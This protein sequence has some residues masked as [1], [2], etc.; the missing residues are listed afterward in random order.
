VRRI[1]VVA[2]DA[3]VPATQWLELHPGAS[4]RRYGTL[5]PVAFGE[6]DACWLLDAPD[7]AHD[8]LPPEGEAWLARGGRLLVTG[9]ASPR[10]FPGLAGFGAHPLFAQT[11][12]LVGAPDPRSFGEAGPVPDD[13]SVVAVALHDPAGARPRAVRGEVVAWERRVGEGGVLRL[14]LSPPSAVAS[15]AAVAMLRNALL[16]DAIP[17]AERGAAVCWPAP[18]AAAPREPARPLPRLPDLGAWGAASA[19][20]PADSQG[21]RVRTLAGPGDARPAE[22]WCSGVRVLHDPA[23]YLDGVRVSSGGDGTLTERWLSALE[24]PVA[25]WEVEASATDTTV[26][27]DW[28]TDLLPAAPLPPGALGD[29]S[30]NLTEGGHRVWLGARAAGMQVALALEGGRVAVVES[31]AGPGLRFTAEG[32]GRLRLALIAATGDAD[33]D[34]TLEL[35]RRKPLVQLRS[36]RAQHAR[37]LSDY[38]SAFDAAPDVS[39]GPRIE[40]AKRALDARLVE[41]PGLGRG[42]AA[43]GGP[44]ML[45]GVRDAAVAAAALLGVGSRDAARDLLRLL[46]AT[47]DEAGRPAGRI[48]PGGLTAAGGPDDALAVLALADRWLR[49][50]GD[51]A[52]LESRAA[53]LARLRDFAGEEDGARAD[54]LRPEPDDGDAVLLRDLVGERW[55]LDPDARTGEVRLRPR[56]PAGW[57]AMRLQRLRVGA[58]VLDV[59]LRRRFDRVSAVVHRVSGPRVTISLSLDA[60]KPARLT[61][62]DVELA[63]DRA[64]FEAEGEHEVLFAW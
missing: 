27:L 36:Q 3:D 64:A 55:G 45:L 30:Y 59:R 15:P 53:Q 4:V 17:H 37:L 44:G 39:L 16:G 32:R 48:A 49:W 10:G 24:L 35:L 57:T 38:A 2:P 18:G 52:H 50:T 25:V 1:A 34:R 56:F 47:V 42:M 22:V 60:P 29:L 21:R 46:L 9:H 62:D 19:E 58:T 26:A 14:A 12:T 23:L 31:A 11:F 33:L 7:W 28:T 6:T 43:R 13:A 8:A 20:R 51:A 40:G 63:G 61:I 54:P 41:V 5:A